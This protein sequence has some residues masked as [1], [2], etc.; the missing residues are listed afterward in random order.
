MRFGTWNVRTL[1][2]SGSL[3]ARGL[4]RLDLVGASEVKWDKAGAVRVQGLYSF[5]ME[6][7]MKIINWEQYFCTPQNSISS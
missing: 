2:R 3:T 5:S 4:A 7:K 6:K 1:Y